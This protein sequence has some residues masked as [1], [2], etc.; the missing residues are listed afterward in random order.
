MYHTSN[1]SKTARQYNNNIVEF[2]EKKCLLSKVLKQLLE[3]AKALGNGQLFPSI[4]RSARH[5]DLK[6]FA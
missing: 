5:S 4:I 2:N 3:T 6:S 1:D